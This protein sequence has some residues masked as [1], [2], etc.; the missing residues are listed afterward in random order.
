MTGAAR[1]LFGNGSFALG[2]FNCPP[3]DPR[4]QVVNVIG[5]AAHVVFPATTVVI[6]QAGREPVVTTPNHVVYYPRDQRYRR[7]LKDPRGDR[8]AFVALSPELLARLLEEASIPAG[9]DGTI[10]FDT[11]PSEAT[12]YLAIAQAVHAL[13]ARSS[14][15]QVEELVYT[16]LER[17]VRA[18][19]SLHESPKRARRYR[20][21]SEHRALVESTKA[22]LGE[23][24]AEHDSLEEIAG[25]L[26]TSPFH[27]ARL[28]REHTGFP[29]HRYR[30]ELR[31]RAAL[32]QL[33]DGVPVAA[34]ARVV[35]FRSH[36]QFT[37]AFRASFG[38][39]P[40]NVTARATPA[41]H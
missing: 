12:A 3:D 28:F 1:M 10:P 34:A 17:V 40:S 41:P 4:W 32:E 35:G 15:L 36:S 38:V 31:L 14:A 25:R 27:L 19:G 16:S 22:L 37:S 39:T 18:A 13:R 33:F 8:S 6:Q 11:G 9:A 26:H 2:E 30:T 7:A 23:R 21:E 20:T 24:F 29:L 5:G